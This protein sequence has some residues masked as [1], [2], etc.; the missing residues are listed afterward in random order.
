MI[1]DIT[2]W[3]YP[4]TKTP[5]DTNTLVKY[6]RPISVES[7]AQNP[8][9]IQQRVPRQPMHLS[10]LA[11]ARHDDGEDFFCTTDLPR[12][13]ARYLDSLFVEARIG[14]LMFE[15]IVLCIMNVLLAAMKRLRLARGP[16][17][18]RPYLY[19]EWIFLV[20]ELLCEIA[21]VTPEREI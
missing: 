16:V 12:R 20:G 1:P 9:R 21:R 11:I 2:P 6:L 19:S 10:F 18:R 15:M 4:K 3:S 8:R 7:H 17:C 5:N 14:S 13:R